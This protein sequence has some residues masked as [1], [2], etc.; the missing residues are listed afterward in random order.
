MDMYGP[1]KSTGVKSVMALLPMWL[2]DF[3]MNRL[4]KLLGAIHD[5]MVFGTKVPLPSVARETSTF[6]TDMWRGPMWLNTNY[7]VAEALLSKNLTREAH[8]LMNATLA[9]VHDNYNKYG[10]IFEF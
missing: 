7:M 6:S 5:K 8:A 10:V 3:P 2:D 1:S 4:P 9:V